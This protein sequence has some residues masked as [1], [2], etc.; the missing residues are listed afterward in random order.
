MHVSCMLVNVSATLGSCL[1]SLQLQ[2]TLPG[3]IVAVNRSQRKVNF[4]EK[5]EEVLPRAQ[6]LH[7]LPSTNLRPSGGLKMQ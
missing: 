4:I 7:E 3:H 5:V 6:A 2:T 1:L